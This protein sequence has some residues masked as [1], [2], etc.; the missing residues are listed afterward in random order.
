MNVEDIPVDA[1]DGSAIQRAYSQLHTLILKGELRP[2]EK[3]KIDSLRKRLDTGASPI[4]EALSLLT[5]DHLVERIDQRGFRTTNLTLDN[6]RE[7][8]NLRRTL[9][10]LALRESFA[11]A[12]TKWE[13]DLVLAHH[14][15]TRARTARHEEMEDRHKD[16]HMTL[17]KN[18]TSPIL[19][20]MCSQLYDLSIRYRYF[21]AL[22]L[23]YKARNVVDEHANILNAAIDRDLDTT[24]K[25]LLDH[26]TNTGNM[27]IDVM[28]ERSLN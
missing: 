26:C 17:L 27:L 24:S 25:L 21:A 3:L 1:P 23:D 28:S 20:K 19:L 15:L 16:F 22:T 6:F 11:N 8:L 9:E 7:I 18:A 12:T 5:S 13:E 4:R 10:N 14:R 2:G